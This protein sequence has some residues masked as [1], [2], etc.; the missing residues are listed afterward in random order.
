MRG[1]IIDSAAEA[2][3]FYPK[4]VIS[5]GESVL[6]EDNVAAVF[7]EGDLILEPLK[8]L[9]GETVLSAVS[10]AYG[11]FVVKLEEPTVP[12]NAVTFG[13]IPVTFGG[14]FVTYTE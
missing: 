12:L 11:S 8:E 10:L 3:S 13:G 5:G 14:E 4:V 2:N 1:R 9:E 7:T 6:V